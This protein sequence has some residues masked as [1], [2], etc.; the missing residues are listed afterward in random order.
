MELAC[1]LVLLSFF[2]AFLAVPTTAVE[3]ETQFNAHAMARKVL[4]HSSEERVEIIA[5]SMATVE[6]AMQL[7]KN[8]SKEQQAK[9]V[10]TLEKEVEQM[11]KSISTIKKTEESELSPAEQ[12]KAK[13]LRSTMKPADQAMMEKMNDWSDR[14]NRKTRL[15]AMDVVS[16]LENAIHFV[17]K[18]ALSGNEQAAKNL[19]DVLAKMTRMS[20]GQVAGGF[21]H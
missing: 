17:K 2:A 13:H 1:R 21:L 6:H 3:M 9:I 19:N 20:G 16:K 11:K 15:G 18:G 14:M 4:R 5:R 7:P 8:A 12:E 10:Q